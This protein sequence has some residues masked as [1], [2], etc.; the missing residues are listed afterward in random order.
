MK[1]YSFDW[2][3]GFRFGGTLIFW[4]EVRSINQQNPKRAVTVQLRAPQVRIPKR[5]RF[6]WAIPI[7]DWAYV[8]RI[9]LSSQAG[10]LRVKEV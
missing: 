6:F 5:L 9:P 1:V 7:R 3:I 4:P 10:C 2:N 8:R